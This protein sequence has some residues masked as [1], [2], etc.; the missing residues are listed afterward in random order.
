M[1]GKFEEAPEGN[2][3]KGA[4][5]FKTKCS[6]CHTVAAGAHKQ[7]CPVAKLGVDSLGLVARCFEDHLVILFSYG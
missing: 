1:S 7:V 2:P 5:I 6:Q 4:K 3:A